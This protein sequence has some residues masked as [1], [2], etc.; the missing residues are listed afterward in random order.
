M[1]AGEALKR[2]PGERGLHLAAVRGGNRRT[3]RRCY[4]GRG[5]CWRTRSTPGAP[6]SWPETWKRWG[7][8]K[9]AIT[10]ERPERLA[11][12]LGAIFDKALLY[13]GLEGMFWKS[14]AARQAWSP[15]WWRAA[16]GGRRR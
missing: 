1:S 13:V 15:R 2:F 16:P 9:T 7:A 6:G 11:E 8:R 5:A 14:E 10:N 4:R 12:R 3:W